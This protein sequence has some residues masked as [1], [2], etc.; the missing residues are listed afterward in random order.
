[1]KKQI[2]SLFLSIL[3]CFSLATTALA[4]GGFDASVTINRETEGRIFVTVN[5]DD[6]ILAA[7]KPT[8]SVPCE[9]EH[10]KV[11]LA[12]NPVECAVADGMVSFAVMAKGTYV[13]L[14]VFSVT[15]N[16]G[17]GSC[18]TVSALTEISGKLTE[19]PTPTRGGYWYFNGW[20]TEENGGSQVTADTVFTENT[21]IYAH[22][23]YDEPYYPSVPSVPS[24]PSTSTETTE[25]EDGST[26]TTVTDNKTGTVTETTEKVGASITTVETK[27]DGTV[28]EKVENTDG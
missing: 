2:I 28:T 3:L 12:G 13:V 8:L 1:M 17:G 21:T 22:W 4:A 23:Y 18:G 16:A 5:A 20:Y 14:E 10:A 26:T 11:M 15:F 25:N 9:F 19:L 7:K 6:A 27:K 24:T